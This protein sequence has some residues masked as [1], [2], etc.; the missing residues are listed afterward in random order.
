MLHAFAGA[1]AFAGLLAFASADA[2]AAPADKPVVVFDTTSGPFEIELD[3]EKAP[4]TV[5]NFLKYVDSGFFDNLVF[6]RVIPG[7][8]V[9]GGG[10][11]ERMTEKPT[12]PPVKNEASNGVSNKRGTVAMAR[13]NNP[14]SA[15]AQFFVN[16]VDNARGL[17]P[18]PGS[19]GYTVFGQVVSGMDVVDAIAKVPTGTRGT[20]DDVPVKPVTIKSAKRKA[21]A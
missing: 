11:D 18:R 5:D 6:H 7:F 4:L 17:D 9:Q 10:M 21:K 15:T 20:H 19:A 8:M 12:R 14:D 2:S 16:L 1:V 13:T 3:A